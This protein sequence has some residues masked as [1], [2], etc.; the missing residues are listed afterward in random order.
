M[1]ES[2]LN[3]YRTPVLDRP[4]ERS[5]PLSRTKYRRIAGTI[6]CTASAFWCLFPAF[7][8]LD[9]LMPAGVAHEPIGLAVL[10][11]LAAIGV[12]AFL[13]G[14]CIRRDQ[15]RYIFPLFMIIV[16]MTFLFPF[17]LAG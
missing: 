2:E 6:I 14:L 17:A 15:Q 12:A 8:F 4:E 13:L 7:A 10:G 16:T 9:R 3:P 5:D 1:S 11:L